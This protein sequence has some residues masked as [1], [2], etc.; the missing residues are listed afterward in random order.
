MAL[1]V[2]TA[3]DVSMAQVNLQRVRLAFGRSREECAQ[4]LGITTEGYRLKEIGRSP[5]TGFDLARL[6]DLFGVPLTVAF[7][8]YEPSADERALVRHL[9]HAA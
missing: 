3:E 9:K 2:Q 5:V 8:E 6:A 4:A 7:P 1:C